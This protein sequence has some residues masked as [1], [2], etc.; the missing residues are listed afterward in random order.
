MP[1]GAFISGC[2]GLELN[3]NEEAFFRDV[4]PWGLILFKRNIDAPDQVK[5]LTERFRQIVGR[6][7][8][9]VLVDQE[10]GRVQRM[11]QPHWR[12]Y[13]AARRYGERYET[14][15]MGAMRAARLTA[16]LIAD[17]LTSVGI[18]VDCLPVLDVPAAG[19][20]DVIGDRAY[21]TSTEKVIVLARQAMTGLM[22]GGVLPVIKHIPGHGQAN[23]DSHLTVPVV[24]AGRKQLET[25]DFLPFAAFSDAPLAMTGHVVYQAIDR[26]NPATLSRKVV[27]LIRKQIGFEGLLMTDDLSMKALAGDMAERVRR[28]LAAGCD[29]MLHC[30]GDFTEMQAVAG[31]AGELKGRARMRA[32]SAL[33]QLRKPTKFDKKLAAKELDQL[34]LVEA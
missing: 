27:R 26:D 6:R 34:L 23:V 19:S 4:Q 13:P 25:G 16:Q 11:G 9:P 17:D 18:N 5:A 2:A 3:A 24:T 31:A 32:R 8:A 12:K 22:A 21:S 7:N 29:M 14:D 33:K 28:A 15:P 10:G 1:I 20:H 30:N